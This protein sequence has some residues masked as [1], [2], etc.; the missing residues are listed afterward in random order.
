MFSEGLTALRVNCFSYCG[1]LTELVFPK[2]LKKIAPNVFWNS[3]NL[4]SI[5]IPGNLEEIGGWS[6]TPTHKLT[7][8][9]P[10]GSV[11]E[12]WAKAYHIHFEKMKE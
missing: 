12:P 10:A 6:F 1:S 8:H 11:I 2:S 3:E 4:T 9:A 7:I 5:T